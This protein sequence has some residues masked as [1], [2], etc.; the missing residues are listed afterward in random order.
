MDGWI[1]SL[2][3]SGLLLKYLECGPRIPQPA[4][5]SICLYGKNP[6]VGVLGG[7]KEQANTLYTNNA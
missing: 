2:F 5:S 4:K 1:H 3:Y 7:L 6:G